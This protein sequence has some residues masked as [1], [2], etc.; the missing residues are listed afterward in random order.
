MLLLP[1]LYE[2]SGLT[3]MRAQR[4]GALPIARRVGGLADTIEDQV[5][6]FLFDEYTS[7]DLRIALRRATDLYRSEPDAWALNV[8]EAMGRDFGWETS[9]QRYL[10]LYRRALAAHAGDDS[11]ST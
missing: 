6:G 11:P 8:A 7:A 1:S 9:A 2:P 4:Y 3:Q 10:D 5:T